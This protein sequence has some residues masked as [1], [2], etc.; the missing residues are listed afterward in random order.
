MVKN[1]RDDDTGY[2]FELAERGLTH[3]IKT[4]VKGTVITFTLKEIVTLAG[5]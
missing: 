4:A 2:R 3:E 5:L 1:R